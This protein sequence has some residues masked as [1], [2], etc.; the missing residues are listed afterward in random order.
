VKKE[1]LTAGGNDPVAEGFAM[2]Q[3]V[4]RKGAEESQ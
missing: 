3:E 1:S 4:A 2:E